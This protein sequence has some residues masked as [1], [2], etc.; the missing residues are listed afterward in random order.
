MLLYTGDVPSGAGTGELPI[1]GNLSAYLDGDIMETK[2]VIYVSVELF[3]LPL[4]T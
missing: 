1:I 2:T 3:A 4:R